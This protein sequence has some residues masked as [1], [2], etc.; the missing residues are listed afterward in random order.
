MELIQYNAS[1]SP[2]DS[3]YFCSLQNAQQSQFSY[4]DV[5]SISPNST[6]DTL[7]ATIVF[8]GAGSCSNLV[9]VFDVVV[10]S[11]QIVLNSQMYLPNALNLQ[12]TILDYPYVP[13]QLSSLAIQQCL[14]LPTA[15][16]YIR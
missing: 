7:K 9:V 5:I 13:M 3:P 2:A 15:I 8:N 14:L 11:A 10:T 6:I 12:I 1:I 4:F 16:Y